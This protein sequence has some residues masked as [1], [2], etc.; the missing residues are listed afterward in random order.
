MSNMNDRND[1]P[2]YSDTEALAAFVKDQLEP[3]L[4]DV[5][6]GT[7]ETASVMVVPK[8]WELKS[9]KPFL[10]ENREHPE[11]R[12]GRATLTDL[13]SFIEHVKR[14]ASPA[15]AIF[16]VRDKSGAPFLVSV[17][18]YHSPGADS[19]AG[20][21]QHRGE[22]AFPLDPTWVAWTALHDKPQPQAQFCAF[23]DEHLGDMRDPASEDIA[24][25]AK[26]Y[27]AS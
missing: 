16:L 8:G 14:F 26:E 10:D 15:S 9:V 27:L 13:E 22:Y 24:G 25:A 5:N 6:S 18:D 23:L 20:W 21:C 17:L 19:P 11:R 12:K 3:T 7:S 1:T 2:K 4:V